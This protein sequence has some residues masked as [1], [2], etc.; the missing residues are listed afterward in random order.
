MK[1]HFE[2]AIFRIGII[3][4]ALIFFAGFAA[5]GFST[6]FTYLHCPE[7]SR[8]WCFNPLYKYCEGSCNPETL[9]YNNYLNSSSASS[10]LDITEMAWLPPGFTYG[11]KPNFVIREPFFIAGLIVAIAFLTNHL[12][13][14]LRGKRK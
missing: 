3:C 8:S 14:N 13:Y 5:E 12:L 4:I 9:P 2:K 6:K 7:D 10:A 11:H 1:Y